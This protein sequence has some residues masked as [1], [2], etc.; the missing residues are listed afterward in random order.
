MK[1]VFSQTQRLFATLCALLFIGSIFLA[2]N[3]ALAVSL[4]PADASAIGYN[5]FIGELQTRIGTLQ[6]ESNG[7]PTSET[8]TKLYDEM[9]FQRATQLTIFVVFAY[10]EY[11]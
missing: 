2:P 11:G 6:F 9:D 10:G 3:N 1:R 4:S 8:I 5:P 7:Y